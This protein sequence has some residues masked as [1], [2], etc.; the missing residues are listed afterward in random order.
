KAAQATKGKSRLSAYDLLQHGDIPIMGNVFTFASGKQ[1]AHTDVRFQEMI[2][3]KN[4]APISGAND[5][6]G[7]A[8]GV[9]DKS[10]NVKIGQ[11][12]LYML[13]VLWGTDPYVHTRVIFCIGILGQRA[14]R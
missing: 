6:D 3:T 9:N 13:P 8:S 7:V 5:G 14:N 10:L 4:R 12:F 11:K 1:P 2:H